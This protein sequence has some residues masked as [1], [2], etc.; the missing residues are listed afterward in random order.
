MAAAS[1]S[2][3]N[4]NT[5]ES[6]S[7]DAVITAALRLARRMFGLSTVLVAE[8]KHEVWRAT[9]VVDDAFGLAPGTE[10]PLRDTF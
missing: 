9:H 8:T 5:D 6:G 10:L 1:F 4:D 2:G 7:P 3:D